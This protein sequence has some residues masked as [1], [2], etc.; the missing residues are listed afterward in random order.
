MKHM[1]TTI[2]TRWEATQL[3]M[4]TK[5]TRLTHKITIQLHL[6][7]ESSTI[8][9]SRSRRPVRKLLDTPLYFV[10]VFPLKRSGIAKRYSAGIRAGWLAVPVQAGAGNFPSP[11]SDRLW[12]HAASIQ[13]VTGAI[14]LGVKRSGREIDHSLPSS[15]EVENSWNYTSTSQNAVNAWCSVEAQG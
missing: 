3:V 11:R 9:S 15:A 8:C 10:F 5:L 14:C 4:A 13:W 1:L 12:C 2:N 7:A 6:V